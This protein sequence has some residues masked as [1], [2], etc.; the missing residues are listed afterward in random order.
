M[1]ELRDRN[2]ISWLKLHGCEPFVELPPLGARGGRLARALDGHGVDS[3]ATERELDASR[4]LVGLLDSLVDGGAICPDMTDQ[5]KMPF[6]AYYPMEKG[7]SDGVAEQN[8]DSTSD[9][10]SVSGVHGAHHGHGTE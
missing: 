6:F 10:G 9:R 7:G 3:V 4:E 8:N 5:V 2:G 1:P